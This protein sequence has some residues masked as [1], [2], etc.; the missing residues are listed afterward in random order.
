MPLAGSLENL[1]SK[2][3][4]YIYIS[5]QSSAH[6]KVK[7]KNE[8]KKLLRRRFAAPPLAASGESQICLAYM[9]MEYC[10]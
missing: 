1:K 9:Y 10:S 6:G 3:T 2:I 7:K 5:L 8:I 4:Y